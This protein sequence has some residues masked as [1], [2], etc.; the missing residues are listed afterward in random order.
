MAHAGWVTAL[1]WAA[2]N[3]CLVLA[4]GCSE[5]SVRLYT[6]KQAALADLPNLLPTPVPKD[7]D[8]TTGEPQ[9]GE[10][11]TDSSRQTTSS[12]SQQADAAMVGASDGAA[13]GGLPLPQFELTT[14]AVT[15]DL[16]GVTCIDLQAST[17]SNTGEIHDSTLL[18]SCAIRKI[19]RLSW[20]TAQ[21]G[22]LQLHD[23]FLL[24]HSAGA[25]T[26][27]LAAGKAAGLVAVWGSGLLPKDLIPK[28]SFV[29]PSMSHPPACYTSAHGSMAVTGVS[30]V[31]CCH[32]AQDAPGNSQI[33]QSLLCTT[34]LDGAVKAW[35]WQK[36]QVS[37]RT[38]LLH[39]SSP[40]PLKS[41]QRERHCENLI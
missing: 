5:G 12:G 9:A 31:R 34:G 26:L 36:D 8:A 23:N 18:G 3:D 25:V 17:D 39:H 32:S 40:Y 20:K 28:E 24:G 15:A 2:V 16:R 4:T 10:G 30:W 33:G 1:S 13:V 14:V 22:F 7:Q 37:S 6:A 35:R 41:C 11:Q 29:V 19:R 38:G 27:C 21:L